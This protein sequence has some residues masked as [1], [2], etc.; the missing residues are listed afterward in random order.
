VNDVTEWY[1]EPF[2]L[3]D[4]ADG[5]KG[6]ERIIFSDPV[7]VIEAHCVEE[8]VPAIQS[9]QEGVQAGYYAAGYIA[10]EAGPAF[11]PAFVVR[12]GTELPLLWFGLFREP[13]RSVR[14]ETEGE[15]HLT[16]WQPSISQDAYNRHIQIIRDAISRG[17]TYQVNYTMR[18]RA[19]FEKDDLAFYHRLLAAQQANYSAY[20]NL[21]RFRILSASPEL[22]FRR[23]GDRIITKPMKGTA[24][25]GRFW[26]EDQ[27]QREWLAHSE[28]NQAENLMIVDLLR[29][30]LARIAETGSVE[31][32]HLFEIE[33]YPTVFQMTST[34]TAKVPPHVTLRDI[35]SVLFPC[36]SITGAPKV[37]T[38]E[39]IAE[40]EDSPR[41]VY[42]GTIGFVKPNGDAVFN[43]AIRTV[44]VDTQK[45]TAEYGVGGGITY[46]ST[47]EGEYL[48]ALA[49]AALL[50]E[51]WPAFEL[52]ETMRLEN[53]EYQLL[54]RHL[55]RLCASANYFQIPL[56]LAE[57]R[58]TLKQ[59]V[60]QYPNEKRRV[61]LL[62]S[63][64]GEARVEST[65]L[66][67]WHQGSMPV[68][69]AGTP[70]STKDR[71]LYHK[72]THRTMYDVRR[73]EHGD[74]FDVLLRNEHGEITEFT[75]GNIVVEINGQKW[76]PPRECGLLAG[77]LRA[78]LLERGEIQ[79]RVI[80]L[81]DLK[82]AEKVWFINSVRGWVPVHFVSDVQ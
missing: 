35:F 18:L 33:R 6:P 49:K 46:D 38:M 48:E 62:V 8:V 78:E 9:V 34:V 15:Y 47:A 13:Q 7:K 45:G 75:M 51:Q 28:K 1:Q 5:Q 23:E 27:K 44:V 39:W 72:T 57:I 31:V 26:E 63:Q 50:T 73:E 79:E 80:T 3:F 77:T 64:K 20:L 68:R 56:H 41:G 25:R 69:I 42:C 53:G 61:R 22:F 2:L 16:D 40:L 74:V 32:P 4:F 55:Q 36:G 52:L 54:E 10:Y 37:K 70:V 12:E 59:H 67:E 82:R 81:S 14:I 76:T 66:K 65:V 29:N 30:D 21:G 71:F 17:E 11:D 58:E 43:V 24:K 60:R 19:A